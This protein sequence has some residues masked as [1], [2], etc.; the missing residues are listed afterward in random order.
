VNKTVDTYTIE[1]CFG[2]EDPLFPF[3]E[4]LDRAIKHWTDTN[5]RCI[6]K[7]TTHFYY[8]KTDRTDVR[9]VSHGVICRFVNYPRFPST[10]D[11]LLKDAIN[12]G[13]EMVEAL[14]GVQ[15]CLVIATDKTV[16]INRRY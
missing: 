14:E 8:P 11:Q 10:P 15:T 16:W 12:F 4:D 9:Q 2:A 3:S 13:E 6:T 7:T 5:K 1:V